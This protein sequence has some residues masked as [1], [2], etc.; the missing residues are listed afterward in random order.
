MTEQTITMDVTRLPSFMSAWA[1]D[2]TRAMGKTGL[3]YICTALYKRHL[4]SKQELDTFSKL[5]FWGLKH[6][7][8]FTQFYRAYFGKVLDKWATKADDADW[9]ELRRWAKHTLVLIEKK[10]FKE[11]FRSFMERVVLIN[12]T[13]NK[14]LALYTLPEIDC[15]LGAVREVVTA[16]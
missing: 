4:L 13:V 16:C 12:E 9:L 5:T 7:A 1:F 6:K 8:T 10:R 2:Q 14:S 11:A 15:Y 3:C